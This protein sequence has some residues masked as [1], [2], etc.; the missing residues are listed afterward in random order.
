MKKITTNSL[1]V[2]STDELTDTHGGSFA[3]DAGRL[4]RFLGLDF[5]YGDSNGV[6]ITVATIDFIINMQQNAA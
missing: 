2:L 1:Q 4:L 6:G 5:Y 3:Y